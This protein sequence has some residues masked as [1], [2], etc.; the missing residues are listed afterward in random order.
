[1]YWDKIERKE[2][3][4]KGGNGIGNRKTNES[5]GRIYLNPDND[6]LEEPLG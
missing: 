6:F 4:E 3:Y 2:L 5:I 1:M